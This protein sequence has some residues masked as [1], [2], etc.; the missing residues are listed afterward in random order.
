MDNNLVRSNIRVATS[1]W[2][3][4][5]RTTRDSLIQLTR[6]H[7]LSLL[8]GEL[9]Y[10]DG[11]WYVS[12]TGL[13]R[14]ARINRCASIQ[15]YPVYEFCDASAGRWAFEAIVYKSG[16]CKG[17]V[18]YG[19]ADPSNVS[20]LVRGAEMRIAETRAVN[21]ALRKAYGIG[22]CSVEEMGANRPVPPPDGNG[23]HNGQSNGNGT[24]SLR[25]RL[26]ETISRHKL[27]GA[28]VKQYAAD[29]CGT[30]TIREAGREAISEFIE[31]LATR[32]EA[33]RQA[34]VADLARYA[35]QPAV[36]PAQQEVA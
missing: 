6:D 8:A 13:L 11:R 19:D 15:V 34:L 30:T 32:A 35:P 27:D 31:H 36:A 5:S 1:N 33:D 20:P 29:F 9:L 18:G 10:L 24:H 12:H 14:I 17:F 26:L 16:R 22:I 23:D 3:K 7:H 2:G 21:R 28:Q 4:L 25:D